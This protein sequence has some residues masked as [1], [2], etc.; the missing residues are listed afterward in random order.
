MSTQ[1]NVPL[2][3]LLVSSKQTIIMLFQKKKKK[4]TTQSKNSVKQ[5]VIY[6]E[7]KGRGQGR[8]EDRA[9]WNPWKYPRTCVYFSAS[10]L[11]HD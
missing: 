11:V 9:R 2:N 7:R 5:G 8:A 1:N 10:S 4:S 3:H 6:R